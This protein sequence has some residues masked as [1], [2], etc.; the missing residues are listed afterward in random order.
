[1]ENSVLAG[2]PSPRLNNGSA[3]DDAIDAVQNSN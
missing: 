3:Q 1:M 2:D